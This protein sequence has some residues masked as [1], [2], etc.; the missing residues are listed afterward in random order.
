MYQEATL[1]INNTLWGPKVSDLVMSRRTWINTELAS[2]YNVAAPPG[3]TLDNFVPLDLPDTRSGILTNPGFLVA[4]S[5]PDHSSIIARGLLVNATVLCGVNPAFNP[6]LQ[7]EIDKLKGT[8]ATWTERQKAEYRMT[9]QPCQSCHQGFDAYGLSL[10]NYDLLARYQTADEQGRP[11]DSSVT[12]PPSAGGTMAKNVSDMAA[13]IS[14]NGAFATCVTK[15]I[16][17]FGLAEPS[18][19]SVDSC[20]T[21]AVSN[22]F[23]TGADQSF[24]AL[25]RAVAGSLPISTRSAGKAM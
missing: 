18:G 2:I 22:A 15:N 9:N 7:A 17:V 19:L 4:R 8:Q 11:I 12:L 24:T 20:A 23:K 14:S 5:R 6:D 10:G 3:A 25:V 1:F 21:R 16:L 13:Q